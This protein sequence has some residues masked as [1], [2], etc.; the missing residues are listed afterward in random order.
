MNDWKK[1]AL[2]YIER[3]P[4][5]EFMAED[6]RQW[7]YKHGCP[8]PVNERNWGAVFIIARNKGVIKSAGF[9][10]KSGTDANQTIAVVWRKV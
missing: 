6:V 4:Q 3:Y 9:R 10:R 1:E 2:G 7:A 8:E 5:F